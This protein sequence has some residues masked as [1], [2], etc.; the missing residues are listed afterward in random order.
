MN[1]SPKPGSRVERGVHYLVSLDGAECESA[2]LARDMG[3]DVKDLRALLHHAVRAGVVNVRR[4]PWRGDGRHTHKLL[5]SATPAAGD[6]DSDHDESG[7]M[8]IS[9]IAA[10]CA[11]PLRTRAP[12]SVFEWR[13]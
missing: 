8:R 4:V 13:P 9:I 2:E 3:A 11:K 7:R 1:Y 12:R 6:A 10:A 5:W